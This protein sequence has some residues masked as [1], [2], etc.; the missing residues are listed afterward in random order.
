MRII[1]TYG[2]DVITD[3]V[4]NRACLNKTVKESIKS[5]LNDVVEVDS[6]GPGSSTAK[7][8]QR[9]GQ[10]ALPRKQGDWNCP[11]CDFL[12]FA[13]NIKCLRCDGEF[14]ERYQ[15]L[16]EDQEHLPLKKGDWICK[17]CNYV[18]FKRNAFCLKC[19]WK[20]PKSLNSQDSIESRDDLEHGRNPSISFVQDGVQLKKWQI[21]QKNAPLSDEDS[22]FWSADDEGDDSRAND[23]LPL[24]D[25]KFLESFPIAGGKTA[26]SQDPLA[27]DKWKDEMSRRNKGLPTKESQECSRPFSPVRLP[28]SM[29]LIDSDD[30]IAS[31]FSGGVNNKN[32][33]K[34]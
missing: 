8:A 30:D 32:L 22:D 2:L 9:K 19:C 10:L 14:Q 31:W 18:N 17:K 34:A 16:H 7:S 15:L 5:L 4:E 27:R 23:M 12:N 21:P 6:R 24:Q 33:E 26:T 25:Y 20:R 29:E 1:L 28:R 13:K 11:K 3:N